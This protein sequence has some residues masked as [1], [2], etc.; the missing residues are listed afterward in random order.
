MF[1]KRLLPSALIVV[2]TVGCSIACRPTRLLFFMALAIIS[3]F[4]LQMV[5]SHAGYPISKIFF[6][7]YILAHGVFCWIGAPVSWMIA[8][9]FGAAVA[10]CIWVIVHPATG[11]KFTVGTLFLLVWPYGLYA[12]VLHAAASDVWLPVLAI[13]ILGTWACDC[14]ALIGGMLIGKHK[15]APE[16]SPNKTWEG[17]I[18]GGVFAA[19]AGWL[20]SLILRSFYPVPTVTCI[21]ITFVASCFGQFGD[22]AASAVKRMAGVKDYG[23]LLPVHGGVMDKTDSMLFAVPVVY[24]ALYIAG[25]I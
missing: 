9:Y 3:A 14:M 21:V 19:V 22:L 13:G 10:A 8:L 23:R 7:V 2:L 18:T 25:V 15:L 1:R 6:I 20:I 24:L 11:E 16:I 5:L 4:E 12:V 17:A